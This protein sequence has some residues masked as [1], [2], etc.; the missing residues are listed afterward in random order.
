MLIVKKM[1]DISNV[2]TVT[3]EIPTFR[4]LIKSATIKPNNTPDANPPMCADQYPL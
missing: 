3:T 2:V 1:T 4:F